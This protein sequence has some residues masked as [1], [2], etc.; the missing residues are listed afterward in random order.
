MLAQTEKR[1]AMSHHP[2]QAFITLISLDQEIRTLHRQIAQHQQQRVT[3]MTEKEEII[4][5]LDQFKEHVHTLQKQVH[6][7]ELEMQTLDQQEKVQKERLNKAQ[8]TKEH[9]AIKKEIERCK[10]AQHEAETMLMPTW[11]KLEI[12]QKEFT[13]QKQ[14]HDKKIEEFLNHIHQEQQQIEILN[15]QLQQKMSERPTKE[16]DIPQDW[17]DKYSHM[18]L[19]VENPV[20]PVDRN[21][22][23]A[24]FYTIPNQELLRLHKRA[25][26]QCKGCFRLL[27]AS[28]AMH[29]EQDQYE[30][31]P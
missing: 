14:S 6:A 2:F 27:Y 4:H 7:Q 22:C 21:S 1:T 29:I 20:V 10:R 26:V 28:D 25:L 9:Q 12:A 5:R 31:K 13:Q 11:N 8:N 3:Y 23:S 17:F 24:C 16:A 30:T 18:R 15:T 19:Q